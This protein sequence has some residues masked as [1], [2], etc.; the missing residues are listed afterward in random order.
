MKKKKIS[1]VSYDVIYELVDDVKK[2]LEE[3]LPPIIKE[4][5]T[6]RGEILAEFRND[7]KTVVIGAKITE[8]TLT[9]GNTIKIIDE[10]N[11]ELWRGKIESL[12]REKEKV[13][14]VDAGFEAGIGLP[15][16][17]KYSVGNKVVAIKIEEIKQ[18]L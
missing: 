14:S 12:R 17:A 3:I 7:K 16:G 9:D 13:T 8:G 18:T 11:N 15:P 4:T 6:A 5:E 10:N 2:M 1:A